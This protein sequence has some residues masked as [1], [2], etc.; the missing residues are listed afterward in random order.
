MRTILLGLH[1]KAFAYLHDLAAIGL[2]GQTV[3]QV[4]ERLILDGLLS[5]I[6]TGLL[7]FPPPAP[8]SRIRR[9]G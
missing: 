3:E 6:R 9:K 1:P 5:E 7:L 8:R 2:H 4:A